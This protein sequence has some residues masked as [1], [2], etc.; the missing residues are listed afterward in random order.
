MFQISLYGADC[1]SN[2]KGEHHGEA[3]YCFKFRCMGQTVSG[4]VSQF[5]RLWYGE[6]HSEALYCF[7][8]R[9]SAVWEVGC[10]S[11]VGPRARCGAQGVCPWGGGVVLGGVSLD[12]WGGGGFLRPATTGY[13]VR[14]GG[15][16]PT[17]GG[18][19]HCIGLGDAELDC[20]G[21][22]SAPRP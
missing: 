15:F 13:R 12:P 20:I 17:P 7:K 14:G 11:V 10:I 9:V 4:I 2:S 22:V 6:H 8:F 1:F 16:T 3:L 18:A 5:K 19:V 21:A